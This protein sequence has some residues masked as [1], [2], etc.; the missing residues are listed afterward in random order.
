MGR[1]HRQSHFYTAPRVV[2]RPDLPV[3]KRTFGSPRSVIR[4]GSMGMT[5]RR[6]YSSTTSQAQ[7]HRYLFF[8]TSGSSSKT[9]LDTVLRLL[10][11]YIER[12][13]IKGSHSWWTP[14]RVYVTTNIHPWDWYEWAGREAQYPALQRRFTQLQLWDST[15]SQQLILGRQDVL[16]GQFFTKYLSRGCNVGGYSVE[17]L[18]YSR[19]GTPNMKFDFVFNLQSENTPPSP[20]DVADV[21]VVD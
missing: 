1:L 18:P 4:D 21:I 20:P 12:V 8:L 14:K 17:G 10:D 15:G 13:P 2:A 6:P 3:K 16:F 19:P 9:R 11:R 7:P 5:D